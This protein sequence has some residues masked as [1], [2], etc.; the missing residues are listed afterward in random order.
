MEDSNLL[1]VY[2]EYLNKDSK[3]FSGICDELKMDGYRI[4]QLDLSDFE[5]GYESNLGIKIPSKNRNVFIK[6]GVCN[7]HHVFLFSRGFV[8]FLALMYCKNMNIPVYLIF[9]KDETIDKNDVFYKYTQKIFTLQYNLINDEKFNHIGTHYPLLSSEFFEPSDSI[10]WMIYTTKMMDH[11]LTDLPG[12][13]VYFDSLSNSFSDFQN[14]LPACHVLVIV[15]ENLPD[16]K[17]VVIQS[18]SI[19]VPV[20]ST[21]DH[22]QFLSDYEIDT[23]NNDLLYSCLNALAFYQDPKCKIAADGLLT[24]LIVYNLLSTIS[25]R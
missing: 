8:C 13:I 25:I 18:L 4:F 19:G 24:R 21:K 3:F 11:G 20:A 10:V 16:I 14:F 23:R 1:F 5:A 15:N 6:I 9:E 2:D 22:L 7:P 17:E 12:M